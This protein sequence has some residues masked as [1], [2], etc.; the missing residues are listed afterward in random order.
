MMTRCS[1]II[2]TKKNISKLKMSN[3]MVYNPMNKDTNIVL[4][5]MIQLLMIQL[6]FQIIIYDPCMVV[7]RMLNNVLTLYVHQILEDCPDKDF[8]KQR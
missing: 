3:W 7:F 8:V 2:I 6:F 5:L 4:R 1:G